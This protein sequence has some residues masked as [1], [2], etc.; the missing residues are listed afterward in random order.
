[1]STTNSPLPIPVIDI[2]PCNPDAASQLL[3][4][5]ATYG[6]VFIENNAATGIPPADVERVFEL[7]KDFFASPTEVKQEVAISSNKAGKNHGWL[8]RGVEKLDPGRQERADV[9]EYAVL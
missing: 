2:S 4:S 3:S 6:F 5:A 9:K 7:S 1:M 8:S